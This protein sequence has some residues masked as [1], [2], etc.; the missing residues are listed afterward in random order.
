MDRK[1]LQKVAYGC[2]DSDESGKM[3][4]TGGVGFSDIW[5]MPHGSCG[6]G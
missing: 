1:I 2:S 3:T 5:T 4:K 6:K